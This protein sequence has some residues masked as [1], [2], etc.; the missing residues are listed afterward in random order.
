MALGEGDPAL[1]IDSK[2]R[3]FLLRLERGKTFQYHQG[4]VPHDALVGCEDG[5]W[6]TSSSGAR[7]LLLRP[8]LADFILKMKRGAQVVYPKDLGPILIFADIAPGMTVLEAGTGSGALT[9]ALSRAV[10]PAGRVV[11]VELREDHAAHARKTLERWFGTIPPNVEIRIGDVAEQ[12]AV[13]EPERIVLDLPEPWHTLDAAARHQPDGGVICAYLPTVP[14]VQTMVERARASGRFAE[15]E[16]RE[17]LMREWNVSGRSVRPE[18]SMVGHTGFLTF[19]RK[20]ADDHR[21]A[22][23]EK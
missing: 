23:P 19:M 21:G 17:F 9:L 6:V 1:L 10:G 14:Q 8:R 20:V 16:V 3:H 13:V 5:T 7:L 4:S 18:H 22:N 11:S 12:V 15:I 2:G